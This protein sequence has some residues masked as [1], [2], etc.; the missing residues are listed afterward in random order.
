MQWTNVAS[1]R[2]TDIVEAEQACHLYLSQAAR[3]ADQS[4][5]ALT[6]VTAGILLV[7]QFQEINEE[8]VVA[9]W[10]HR[11]QE[12]QAFVMWD[13]GEH[14]E[15]LK[16]L[17]RLLPFSEGANDHHIETQLRRGAYRSL[18]LTQLVRNNS[19]YA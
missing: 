10:L 15:A 7:S 9:E 6:N 18:L 19:I 8:P 2:M 13:R 3:Q 14:G 1:Q 12:E 11:L 4:D 16:L 5:L 17:E